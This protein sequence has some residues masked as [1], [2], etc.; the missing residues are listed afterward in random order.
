MD[1]YFLLWAIIQY[2]FTYSVQIFPALATGISSSLVCVPLTYLHELYVRGG[3]L[4]MY[5]VLFE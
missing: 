4:F 2:Y 1:I 5:F 3:C